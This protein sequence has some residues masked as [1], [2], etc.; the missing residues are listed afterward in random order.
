ML[1]KKAQALIEFILLL[2]IVLIIIFS[3][4][5]LFSLLIRKQELLNKLDDEIALVTKKGETFEELEKKLEDKNTDISF[6]EDEKSVTIILKHN[7]DWF[8][9]ITELFFKN[10]NITL[11]RVV[12][13]E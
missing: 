10:Y 9:P 6:K 13:Y 11:K 1:N 3:T 2:P 12:P 4:I 7:I 5:D 8:S